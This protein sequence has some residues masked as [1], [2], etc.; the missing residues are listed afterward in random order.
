VDR[1]TLAVGDGWI[2]TMRHLARENRMFVVG[3]NPVLH[4][5]QVPAGFPG[6]DRLIPPG[7]RQRNGFW[8]EEGGPAAGGTARLVEA[9]LWSC[10]TRHRRA[11]RVV[12][13]D[14]NIT[15]A[16]RGPAAAAGPGGLP[17]RG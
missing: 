9:G 1:P 12:A 5:D 8:L 2:A 3:A 4:A 10:L 13:N 6:R 14:A 11:F 15:R 7:F 16:A 17:D